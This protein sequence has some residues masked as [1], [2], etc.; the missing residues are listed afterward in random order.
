MLAGE[1]ELGVPPPLCSG[2]F[3]DERVGGVPG[4]RCECAQQDS[5]K[6][7]QETGIRHEKK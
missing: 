5:K 3:S 1:F 6:P 2:V 7:E 4:Q